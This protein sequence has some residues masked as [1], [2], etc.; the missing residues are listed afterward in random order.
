[1]EGSF[2]ESILYY[3]SHQHLKWDLLELRTAVSLAMVLQTRNDTDN[4]VRILSVLGLKA[5][6]V[7]LYKRQLLKPCPIAPLSGSEQA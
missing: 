1:M 3:D 6:L 2:E 5:Q 4:C 7:H